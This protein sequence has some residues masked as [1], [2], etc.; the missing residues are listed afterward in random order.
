[1]GMM[2]ALFLIGMMAM[3]IGARHYGAYAADKSYDRLLAGSAMSVAETLSFAQGEVGVDIPYAAFDM[4]SAAPDDR[5]FYRLYGP[6]DVTITGYGDL[7]RSRKAV[8]EIK[9]STGAHVAFFDATYRG[10]E[11]RFVLLG[12]RVSESGIK[13]WVWV[14]IGHTRL[15]RDALA[16]EMVFGAVLPIV[17]LTGLALL[18]VW[19]GVTRALESLHRVGRDIS[20]REPSDLKPISTALPREAEPLAEAINQFMKRL[21]V[22]MDTL[23]GFI[24]EA[25]H[26]MRTP[27]AALRAQAQEAL[28]SEEP[29]ELKR[30]LRAVD[31]NAAKL[32]RLLNQLLSDATVIHRADLRRFEQF[33]LLQVVR[34]SMRDAVPLRSE[35]PLGFESEL[36]SAPLYGDGVILGE[37]IK[38]LLD[39]AIRHGGGER[40]RIDI[41]LCTRGGAYVLTVADR[42]PGIG[43]DDRERVF[44]RFVSGHTGAPGAGLGLAIVR[45]AAESHGGAVRMLDREGGGLIVELSLPI[46]SETA[47]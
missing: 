28:E 11:V 23:R 36:A 16:G 22:S 44:E 5:V 47:P 29:A 38:N 15:A 21:G 6:G 10:E 40:P 20:R 39:N 30:G 7:P 17:L 18:V 33:D 31:R 46:R 37:A 41:G 9:K 24:A 2:S 13:G 27:L 12:R 19:F 8:E 35:I 43:P 14:Q 34:R 45:Q 25:A 32:T 1:M 4:L 3:Y 42:G 26:Q